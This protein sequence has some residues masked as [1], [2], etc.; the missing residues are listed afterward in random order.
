MLS[1]AF[2]KMPDLISS[3]VPFVSSLPRTIYGGF[4]VRGIADWQ[5]AFTKKGLLGPFLI[6]RSI[7]KQLLMIL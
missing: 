7:Y 1:A 4:E 5:V 6:V 2:W 3:F